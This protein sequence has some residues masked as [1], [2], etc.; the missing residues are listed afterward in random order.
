M[1]F[2]SWLTADTEESIP[3]A[4]SPR[5][6]GRTVYM[7]QPGDEP[8][9]AEDDYRGDGIFDGENAYVWLA[10]RHM[11]AEDL[12]EVEKQAEGHPD[13]IDT[14]LHQIGVSIEL[15]QYYEHRDTGVKYAIFHPL[16]RATG[17]EATL[18]DC[19]FITKRPEFGGLNA[20]E[21]M[22]QGILVSHKVPK[23]RYPLKFSF[24]PNAVYEEL[25][26]SKTCPW[27]GCYYDDA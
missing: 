3:V 13:H 9:L 17:V 16:H 12:A 14:M 26:A 8:A 15:G 24:D 1:G 4:I 25:P 27:Q 10:R 2:F 21:A 7:L 11:S 5:H 20:N 23:P 6:K 18:L 19:N 22:E